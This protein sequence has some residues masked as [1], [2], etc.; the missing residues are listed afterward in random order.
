MKEVPTL[1]TL[2]PEI[3]QNY[4]CEKKIKMSKFQF[5]KIPKMSQKKMT[6]SEHFVHVQQSN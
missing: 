3:F 2:L 4:S 1:K 5:L 6:Y